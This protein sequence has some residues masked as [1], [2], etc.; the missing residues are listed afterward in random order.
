MLCQKCPYYIEAE[1]YA[2]E[3]YKSTG[4]HCF[5]LDMRH[6][7]E[8]DEILTLSE[9][10]KLKECAKRLEKLSPLIPDSHLFHF[11][12]GTV[13]GMKGDFQ[14]AVFH[15]NRCLE[16]FP[17]DALAWYN[18][19]ATLRK[20]CDISGMIKA[21]RMAKRLTCPED[22]LFRLADDELSQTEQMLLENNHQTPDEYM[23]GEKLYNTAFEWM[24]S[25][26]F[27]PA[28]EKFKKVLESNPKHVQSHGNI[29]LCYAMMGRKDEAAAALQKA[30]EIDSGYLPAKQ[31][32]RVILAM[33]P[34]TALSVKSLSRPIEFYK[35]ELL[36]KK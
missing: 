7:D 19:G 10:G 26:R 36:K 4:R 8:I 25:G 1:E 27:E 32:L 17:Y 35:D 18:K 9:K 29:G 28:L 20:L 12:M 30:L 16:I 24:Y 2:I 11:A 5:S 21:L 14:Q 23:E 34:G 15:F 33:K 3:R 13:L 31:N 6:E 22:E